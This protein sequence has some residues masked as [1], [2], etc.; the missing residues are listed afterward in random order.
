MK[1]TF[2]ET[3]VK[4]TDWRAYVEKREGAKIE[5]VYNYVSCNGDYC[6]TKLRITGKVMKQGILK[7]SVIAGRRLSAQRE[8]RGKRS[9]FGIDAIPERSPGGQDDSASAG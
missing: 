4:T 9:T 1:D 2:Y 5:A 6:F 8:N 3:N 7:T